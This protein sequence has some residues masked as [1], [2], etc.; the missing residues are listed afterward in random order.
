MHLHYVSS[1]RR[2]FMLR[3]DEPMIIAI[4]SVHELLD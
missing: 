4:S 1:E 3:L 2:R